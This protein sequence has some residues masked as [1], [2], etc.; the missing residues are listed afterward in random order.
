M[1]NVHTVKQLGLGVL[2]V[3]VLLAVTILLC[4]SDEDGAVALAVATR[5][6]A[7]VNDADDE[8]A[9]SIAVDSVSKTGDGDGQLIGTACDET[10]C[11]GGGDEKLFTLA[12]WTCMNAVGAAG[13]EVAAG[14]D[15]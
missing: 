13:S 8:R 4:S 2:T 7:V 14:W 10:G 11:A 1:F 3:S 12:G 15:E 9:V 5:V 6:L